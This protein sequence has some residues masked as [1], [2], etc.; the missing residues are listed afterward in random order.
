MSPLPIFKPE[1]RPNLGSAV[2]HLPRHP[3]FSSERGARQIAGRAPV[4]PVGRSRG[5]AGVTVYLNNQPRRA[6]ASNLALPPLGPAVNN[7]SASPMITTLPGYSLSAARRTSNASGSS[8]QPTQ[9]ALLR[10]T[11]KS[12]EPA[13]PLPSFQPTPPTQPS[14]TLGLKTVSSPG[15]SSGVARIA[16]GRA[17]FAYPA[18]P[19]SRPRVVSSPL[20][21]PSTRTSRPPTT[22]NV[23][24][25]TPRQP[26]HWAPPARSSIGSLG[27]DG[28]MNAPMPISTRQSDMTAASGSG[29]D[30]L[31]QAEIHLDGQI[32]GHWVLS[33]LEEVL[34]QP[35]TGA[36][37]TNRRNA[38][39]WSGQPLY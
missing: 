22:Q 20:R 11:I 39:V 28:G 29:S 15:T 9:P 24:T 30:T 33:H 5:L 16:N 36:S 27:Q 34:T 13:T 25:A 35:Q 31:D 7:G 38:T 14:A 8:R 12:R 26:Q 1:W 17:A 6:A 18:E 4:L 19:P 23:R 2:R 10:S 37:F 32:L 3:A 21:L